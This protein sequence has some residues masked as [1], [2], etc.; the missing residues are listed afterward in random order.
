VAKLIPRTIG[1]SLSFV[2]AKLFV[3]RWRYRDQ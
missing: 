3:A 2:E 1:R